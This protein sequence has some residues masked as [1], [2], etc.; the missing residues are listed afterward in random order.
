M[1]IIHTAHDRTIRAGV[2]D[3]R[4]ELQQPVHGGRIN[5]IAVDLHGQVRQAKRGNPIRDAVERPVGQAKTG[6]VVGYDVAK[7][8]MVIVTRHVRREAV[9]S[10]EIIGGIGLKPVGS[11]NLQQHVGGGAEK[12]A[13][14]PRVKICLHAGND[15]GIQ[16]RA[17]CGIVVHDGILIIQIQLA[18]IARQ[19]VG[20]KL[21]EHPVKRVAV[22]GRLRAVGGDGVA[23][24]EQAV[25]KTVRAAGTFRGVEEIGGRVKLV[26]VVRAGPRRRVSM[27]V[28]ISRST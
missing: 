21:V 23:G 19:R 4:R 3:V 16:K 18:C 25:G 24:G 28:K 26:R 1:R 8:I 20:A 2:K 13:R 17:G 9:V 15:G 5:K 27:L 10:R 12:V 11:I 22:V 7:T 14:I 6:R